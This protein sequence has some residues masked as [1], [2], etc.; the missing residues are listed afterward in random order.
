MS[1]KPQTVF[2]YNQQL[3]SLRTPFPGSEKI[4]VT[5]DQVR[6]PM[7]AIH[8][9]DNHQHL[10]VYDTSG[11]YTDPEVAI[12]ITQ[13]LPAIRQPW[14]TARDDTEGYAGTVQPSN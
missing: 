2:E 4:Y 8:V 9:D 6:V 14:I 3:E 10:W 5:T 1:A 13:G 11:V 12:D 7:R